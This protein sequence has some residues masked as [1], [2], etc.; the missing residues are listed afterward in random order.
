MSFSQKQSE[1]PLGHSARET[2]TTPRL[3]VTHTVHSAPSSRHSSHH[4]REPPPPYISIIE[5][6]D[7]E[8][9]GGVSKR[10]YNWD[11][12]CCH[13]SF[14]YSCGCG[15]CGKIRVSRSGCFFLYFALAA[16]LAAAVTLAYML[17]RRR[18]SPAK[19]VP[20]TSIILFTLIRTKLD[21]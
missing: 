12:G 4:A 8:I 6:R 10:D 2:G 18:T 13:H 17:T 5:N 3:G 1:C 11:C 14:S 21:S 20:T 15:D 19:Y 9:T 16:I 7:N